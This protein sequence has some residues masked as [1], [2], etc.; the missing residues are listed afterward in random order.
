MKVIFTYWKF[1]VICSLMVLFSCSKE[2]KIDIPGYKKQLVVDGF[3][4]TGSPA[5]VL[6]SKTNNIYAGTNIQN[7]IDGFV[8]GATVIVSDGNVT[9]TLL[10]ICTNNLP[11]GTEETVAEFLGLPVEQILASPICFYVSDEIIGEVGKTYSLTIKDEGQIYTSE[12]S[13]LAPKELD[14]LYWKEEPSLPGYGFSWAKLTDSPVLGNAYK[15]EVKYASAL[16]FSKPFGPFT[17]DRFYN[18]LTFEFAYENPMSFSNPNINNEV[19]GYFAL[20]DT[21]VVKFSTLGQKEYKFFDKKY[22]QIYSAGNPFSTPVNLPSNITGGALG[23]WV[24]F[25]PTFD[26]LICQP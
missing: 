17:D 1:F 15:W 10:E 21:I 18:G 25:S 14:S 19:R 16:T 13:I 22:N 12:T 9:D 3:I 4:E 20:G 2:V 8:S 11:D 6:L 26:T 24:G 7:Y 5:F 23:V